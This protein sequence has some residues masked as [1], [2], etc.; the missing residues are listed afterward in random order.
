MI[1]S[2]IIGKQRF[3][4]RFTDNVESLVSLKYDFQ[5][6]KGFVA[7]QRNNTEGEGH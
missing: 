7:S 2:A 1:N 6:F 5:P 3:N 4:C